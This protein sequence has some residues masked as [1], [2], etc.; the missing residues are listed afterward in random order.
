MT[1]VRMGDSVYVTLRNRAGTLAM[2]SSRARVPI[3]RAIAVSVG[4]STHTRT[5]RAGTPLES[6]LVDARVFVF[7]TYTAHESFVFGDVA[8]DSH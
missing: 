5:A 2:A 1:P 3:A 8:D 7:E 4:D 6:R